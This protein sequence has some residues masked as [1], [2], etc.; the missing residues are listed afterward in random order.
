[1]LFFGSFIESEIL[2]DDDMDSFME[3]L[4]NNNKFIG[5]R[6]WNLLYR[7]STDQRFDDEEFVKKQ[8]EDKLNVIFLIE[9]K[10][11]MILG[12]YSS[13]GWKSGGGS[14]PNGAVYNRDD[15]AYIFGIRSRKGREPF[16][17]NVRSEEAN[18]AIRSQ[19]HYYCLFGKPA[20]LHMDPNGSIR[21]SYSCC[22]SALP[23]DYHMS[24]VAV[25]NVEI[26]QIK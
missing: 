18:H 14:G 9:V 24:Y 11:N 3:L 6:Q 26:F 12:G 20:I 22:Y 17:S 15:E 8:Y 13:V 16:I 7:M 4:T 10:N 21:C 2:T 1:M 25:R 5:R 23:R 19:W